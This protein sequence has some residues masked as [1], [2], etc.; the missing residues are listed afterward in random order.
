MIDDNGLELFVCTR[1]TSLCATCPSRGTRPRPENS[2]SGARS[3]FSSLS[4][5]I[6]ESTCRIA[7]YS[8]HKKYSVDK[9]LTVGN[10]TIG[11]GSAANRGTTPNRVNTYGKS[12]FSAVTCRSHGCGFLSDFDTVMTAIGRRIC[13]K[14]LDLGIRQTLLP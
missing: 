13:L 10:Y 3:S 11:R 8:F 12:R 1:S 6:L 5:L 4:L 7:S 9:S 14:L 2:R